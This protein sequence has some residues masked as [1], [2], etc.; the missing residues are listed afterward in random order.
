MELPPIQAAPPIVAPPVIGAE[1]RDFFGWG[2]LLSLFLLMIVLSVAA[3]F[4]RDAKLDKKGGPGLE[5]KLKAAVIQQSIGKQLG[6]GD[7]KD[8]R[9]L[10]LELE[11]KKTSSPE[12]ARVYL[13]ANAEL[14]APTDAEALAELA[15]W[16]D[17]KAKFVAQLYASKSLDLAAAAKI[18]KALGDSY[19]ERLERAQALEKAGD[20]SARKRLGLEPNAQ[21]MVV[22][23][24]VGCGLLLAGVVLWIV[25]FNSAGRGL[26]PTPGFPVFLTPGN[27]DREAVRIAFAFVLWILGGGL[28]ANFLPIK[29]EIAAQVVTSVF[30]LALVTWALKLRIRGVAGPTWRE[31][32]GDLSSPGK[33]VL[34]GLGAW[35]AAA[36]LL[37][38]TFILTLLLSKVLPQPDHPLN[39]WLVKPNLW[40]IVG[41]YL[42]A[43]VFA[44][45]IEETLFRGALAP[46]IAASTRSPAVGIL[47]SAFLFAGIHPQGIAGWPP[48]A[49]IGFMAAFVTYRTRSLLPAIVLHA[50]HNSVTLLV[51]VMVQ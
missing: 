11:P 38:V 19:L 12:A 18:D 34:W 13:A 10:V 2:I 47:A 31:R 23:M 37:V 15:K 3:T 28:I 27:G 42:A 7:D 1:R 48:L 45:L 36:P 17:P 39:D 24:L 32:L 40:T 6:G 20:K 50:V 33:L 26:T 8:L 46:A 43:A 14:N 35:V 9:A 5:T 21:T 44:P 25:F 30:A 4:I 16:K 41:A 22:G 49:A 29:N 51:A